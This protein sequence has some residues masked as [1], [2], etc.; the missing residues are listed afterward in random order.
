M[1]DLV[2]G[3]LNLN[4]A[5]GDVRMFKSVGSA[6]QDVSFAEHIAAA[7]AKGGLGVDLELG[8]QIKKSIGR[9]A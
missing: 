3:R 5:N 4:K 9:N 2:Q 1:Q 8:F 6:L 7:A